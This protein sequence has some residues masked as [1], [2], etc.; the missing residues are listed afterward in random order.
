MSPTKTRSPSVL[1]RQPPSLLWSSAAS[2][3]PTDAFFGFTVQLIYQYLPSSYFKPCASG[4]FPLSSLLQEIVHVRPW[5]DG[6]MWEVIQRPHVSGRCVKSK[7]NRMSLNPFWQ[8]KCIKLLRLRRRNQRTAD[9]RTLSLFCVFWLIK[10]VVV[11]V[12]A[13]HISNLNLSFL[14]PASLF[15][16]FKSNLC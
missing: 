5:N 6:S 9:L 4:S 16:C 1:L 15:Q 14:Q 7:L 2:S 13:Q 8:W 10:W 11:T 12:S 3:S